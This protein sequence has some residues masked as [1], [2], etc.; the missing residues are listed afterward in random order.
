[1][2]LSRCDI[3]DATVA[4]FLVVPDHKPVDPVPGNVNT[5]KALSRVWGGIIFLRTA[6]LR[7]GEYFMHEPPAPSYSIF[8]FMRQLS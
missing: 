5:V 6:S 3:P 1:M 7:S 4:V 2:A 8:W